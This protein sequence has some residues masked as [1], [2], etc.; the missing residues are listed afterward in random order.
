MKIT[1]RADYAEITPL[2]DRRVKITVDVS[3]DDL[4]ET[5]SDVELLTI[6]DPDVVR[7]WLAAYDAAKA[8]GAQP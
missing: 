8:T 4:L 6:M 5:V 2:D 7:P 3:L 1:I